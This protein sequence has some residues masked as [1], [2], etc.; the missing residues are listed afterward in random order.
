MNSRKVFMLP[1]LIPALVLALA[2]PTSVLAKES[3]DI[4]HDAEYYILDA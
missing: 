1:G 2:G 3:K 4:V